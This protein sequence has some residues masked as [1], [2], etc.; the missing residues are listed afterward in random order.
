MEKRFENYFLEKKV[1]KKKKD[2]CEQKFTSDIPALLWLYKISK[3]IEL[4]K[5]NKWIQAYGKSIYRVS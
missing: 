1:K 5:F 4:L 2:I 3:V